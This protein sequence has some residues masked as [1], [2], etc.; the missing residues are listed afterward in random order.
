MALLNR[1]HLQHFPKMSDFRFTQPSESSIDG[2]ILT[3]SV[4]ARNLRSMTSEELQS[5]WDYRYQERLGILCGSNEPTD[6]QRLIAKTEADRAAEELRFT[7]SILP[8][9]FPFRS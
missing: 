7:P 2:E 9:R 6:E 8:S 4:Y 1:S 3:S 5:E